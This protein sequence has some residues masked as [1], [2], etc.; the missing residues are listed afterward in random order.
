MPNI[1]Q[2]F[3]ALLPKTPRRVGTVQIVGFGSVTL[4]VPGGGSVVVLGEAKVGD[5]VFYRDGVVEGLAP[6]LSAIDIEV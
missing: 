2:A 3:R 4:S 6:A 1:L 5:Q